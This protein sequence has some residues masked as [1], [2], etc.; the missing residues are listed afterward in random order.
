MEK[1][2]QEREI[3]GFTGIIPSAI[4][5]LLALCRMVTLAIPRASYRVSRILEP[6]FVIAG[7]G[8]VARRLYHPVRYYVA[9]DK[10]VQV[11]LTEPLY[12]GLEYPIIDVWATI[13]PCIA[14]ALVTGG[15]VYLLRK[16]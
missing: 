9:A 7:I 5:R 8:L 6:L 13:L 15:L 2:N 11:Y 3:L 16:L 4:D 10:G 14:I 12:E 1:N